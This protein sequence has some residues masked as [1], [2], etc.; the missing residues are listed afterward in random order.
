LPTEAE[1]EYAC[2]A[3]ADT[4][5]SWGSDPGMGLKYAHSNGDSGGRSWPVGSLRP[6]RFGLFDLHGNISEWTHDLYQADLSGI[7]IDAE[8]DETIAEDS[9]RAL[10]GGGG[11]EFVQ[12]L[13]SA[14]R[15]RAKARNGVSYWTGFRI[16]R[17]LSAPSK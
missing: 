12:Y 10:R 5:F 8:I 9:V 15:T 6:N 7:A 17:T 1:C 2:R 3:G 16:A 14:N 11:S 13:R 4:T